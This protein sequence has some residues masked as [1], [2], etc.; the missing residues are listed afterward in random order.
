MAT[1]LRLRVS[2]R[3]LAS[4][5]SGVG[6]SIR[7]D[8]LATYIDLDYSEFGASAAPDPSTSEI[9]VRSSGDGSFS[10]VTIAQL[11]TSVQTQ[12]IKTSAGD[13]NVSHDDGL[14]IINKTVGQATTVNLPTSADKVG[15]VKIVDWKG[16][17]G[18]NNI[19]ISVVGTDKLN[20]NATSWVIASDNGS[21]VLHPLEDG[22]GYAI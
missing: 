8:G 16:D 1:T 15:P 14:I 11:L 21:V 22:S 4:I 13:V 18:T 3:F 2:P 9:L 17:A 19:T 10:I 7:K 5:F 20:G 12:Q 6:T